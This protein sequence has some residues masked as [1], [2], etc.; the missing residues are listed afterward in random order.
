MKKIFLLASL[1]SRTFFTN[2]SAAQNTN[3]PDS[4]HLVIVRNINNSALNIDT[5]VPVSQHEQLMTWLEAQGIHTEMNTP[6]PGESLGS[7]MLELPPIPPAPSEKRMMVITEENGT[8][9]VTMLPAPPVPPAAPGAP[10]PP[11]VQKCATM[12][13]GNPGATIIVMKDSTGK[14]T[15]ICK[16]VIVSAEPPQTPAAPGENQRK[17]PATDNELNVFPNPSTGLITLSFHLEGFGQTNIR[18]TDM[19]GKIVYEEQLGEAVMGPYSKEIDLGTGKGMYT[20]EVSK[21]SNV[22]VKKVMV[23]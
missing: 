23:R 2:E 11:A 22:L 13:N 3:E 20:V 19:N 10:A 12:M 8:R 17:V 7:P 15:T 16:K 9:Q 21:G 14:E 1:I 6:L 18:I 4:I 5:V